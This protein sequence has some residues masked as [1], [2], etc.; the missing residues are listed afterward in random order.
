MSGALRHRPIR[1]DVLD[2]L[3]P[4]HVDEPPTEQIGLWPHEL[5][6]LL[7]VAWEALRYR[8]KTGS[9]YAKPLD[10]AFRLF[11]QDSLREWIGSN[12]A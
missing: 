3:E 6:A 4:G 9:V 2:A 7:S 12:R 8:R 10:E 5:E 11:D 1:I